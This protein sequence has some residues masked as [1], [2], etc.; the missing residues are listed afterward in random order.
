MLRYDQSHFLLIIRTN[1]GQNEKCKDRFLRGQNI[2][3]L[4]QNSEEINKI[5]TL[6]YHKKNSFKPQITFPDAL[7]TSILFLF[8]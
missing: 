3:I 7:Q 4:R 8:L 5:S 2:L 6:S 1:V